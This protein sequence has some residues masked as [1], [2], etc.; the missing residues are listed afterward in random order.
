MELNQIYLG[1][2]YELIKQVP[3]KSVGLVLTDVP[4][5]ITASRL[6]RNTTA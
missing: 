1:D 3:D 4:Y 2:A 6:A 5:L